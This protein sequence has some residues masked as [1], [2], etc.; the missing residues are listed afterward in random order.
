MTYRLNPHVLRH[1]PVH[2]TVLYRF[3]LSTEI[4]VDP[5]SSPFLFTRSNEEENEGGTVGEL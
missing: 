4:N 2:S 1:L 3:D 5:F